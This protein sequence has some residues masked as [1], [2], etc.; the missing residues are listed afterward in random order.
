MQLDAG[1][2]VGELRSPYHD[3]EVEQQG[4][5][6]Y[7]VTLRDGEVPADR[8]FV[9]EW[10]PEPDAEPQAS[11]FT[12][13]VNGETY[14]LAM[15]VPPSQLN[16]QRTRRPREIVFIID[17][18]GSMHGPS[19]AQAKQAL[20]RALKRLVPGDRFNLIAFSD[21]AWPLYGQAAPV[22]EQSL[23]DALDFV[24]DLE[25]EG[26]TELSRALSLALDGGD[27]PTRLRQVVLLTDGAV[28]NES[29]LF[30]LIDRGLGD[31]RLFTVGI[32]SA[33]NG[34]F[35]QKAAQHGRGT[36]T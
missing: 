27:D 30:R 12:E 35:M 8:D 29:E 24:A 36:F 19:L 28:G 26:G 4:E 20:T 15:V 23:A 25:A 21:R 3:I 7:A 5:R 32:G 14:L 18:S 22:R 10:T 33:P 6:R 13:T 16:A 17:V 2:A 11:V 31:S 9:L 34:Y 1:F